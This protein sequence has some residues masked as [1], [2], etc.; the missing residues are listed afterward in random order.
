MGLLDAHKAMA[1]KTAVVVGMLAG[2]SAAIWTPP[3]LAQ[4]S[5]DADNSSG[6]I[7]VTARK[8]EEP[9]LK[10]PVVLTAVQSETLDRLGATEMTDLPK[11]VPG[12]TLSRGVLSN[13][14]F[15]SLRGVG[16]TTLDPGI[17]QSISL[18]ID[19]LAFTQG[20]A[21][22]SGMFDLGQIE[23][24][25]GP[26]ALFHGKASPG[27]V[28]S[29]R[30]ADPTG[31][32]EVIARAGYEFEAREARGEL[33]V[34]GPLGETLKARIAGAYSAAEGYFRN[35]ANPV[36]STGGL[37]P[38]YRR[39]SR[40]RNYLIRGTL[41]WN[42]S[43][44]FNARLKANFV[45]DD[46]INPEGVQLG[47][48]TQGPNQI[49]AP[50][51]FSF[52]LGDDCKLNRYAANSYADPVAFP[53][54][55]NGGVPF[56]RTTQNYGKLEL[57][58]TL[59]PQ[60]SLNSITGF[61]SMKSRNLF[62][63]NSYGAGLPLAPA[64][65]FGRR[66]VTQE[67]RLNSDFDG[68]LNFTAGAYFQDAW[69]RN[70][71]I[72]IG[73]RA[74]GLGGLDSDGQ[75]AIDVRAYSLFGQLRWKIAPELELSGGARW[76]DEARSQQVLNLR[77]NTPNIVAVNRISSSNVA[78]EFSLSYTPTDDLTVFGA[79][80]VAYKSGSFTIAMVPLPGVNNAFGDEKVEGGEIG[81]KSRLG[82]R[83]LQANIAGYYYKYTGLQVGA[84]ALPEPGRL[85]V[86]SVINAGAARTYGIDFDASY[87]PRN[88]EGLEITASINWNHGTYTRLEGIP[89][90]PGQTI[91]LGCDQIINTSTGRFTS[92]N[93]SGTPMI[94]APRWHAS[95]G[96]SYETPIAS[97]YK[98]VI[99]N[100]N[101]FSSR[102]MRFLAINR[103][104]ND[105]FQSAFIKSD[106]SLALRGPRDRWEVAVIGKN[107]NDKITSGICNAGNFAGGTFVTPVVTGGGA[108]G[109]AGLGQTA[110]YPER[111]RSLW[112]RL[113]YRPTN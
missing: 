49:V 105:N 81:I 102:M 37:A 97:S 38:T 109:A 36:P 76:T 2:I 106:V 100:S 30:T 32:F 8:R 70:R 65:H 44:R 3:A 69:M 15:V 104:N 73:S 89:C 53:G 74:I 99:G 16:T 4:D 75:T 79:Y 91:A 85:P 96:F 110:C 39:Q 51:T 93:L 5:A 94:R 64:N 68:P 55:I 40:T 26:Q 80:K 21:F 66:D 95:F 72:T 46:N 11:L 113:T 7:I 84:F 58:Y 108:S 87:R 50:L 57:D 6:E 83:R 47:N 20:L 25:K 92:A 86:I 82:G 78:P 13:G 77:T 42:P 98:L 1:T 107:I 112:I 18:N 17:D 56:G 12:L 9:I 34:S 59:T 63:A 71:V 33:I 28:I 62:L 101:Q 103:P 27:G 19:G 22:A 24:L 67:L 29:I 111:G 48:C 52:I 60:L 35:V 23:V 54:I 90:W 41:L 61:Y 14:L 45:K 31:K 10:V 43:D 88:V